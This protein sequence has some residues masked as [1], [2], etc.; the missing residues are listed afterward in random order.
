MAK[1]FT[2]E[3]KL[4]DIIFKTGELIQLTGFNIR[5]ALNDNGYQSVRL[6]DIQQYNMVW[7]RKL[8]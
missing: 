2:P 6:T 5:Q 4:F 7:D 1:E 3:E 8:S